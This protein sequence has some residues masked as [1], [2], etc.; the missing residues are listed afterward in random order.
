QVA[1]SYIKGGHCPG[2]EGYSFCI[3]S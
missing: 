2:S 1:K 3:T